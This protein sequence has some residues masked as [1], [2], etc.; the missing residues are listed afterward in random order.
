MSTFL[1]VEIIGISIWG[2]GADRD[3]VALLVGRS[4]VTT[5]LPNGRAFS[6]RRSDLK[7]ERT[8]M[9]E[10]RTFTIHPRGYL[11]TAHSGRELWKWDEKYLPSPIKYEPPNAREIRQMAMVGEDLLLMD[12]KDIEVLILKI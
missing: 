12:D 9:K 5:L 6:L 7:T 10:I 11:I 3:G 4:S 2:E 8:D 1:R